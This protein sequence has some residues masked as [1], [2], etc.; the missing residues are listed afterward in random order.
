MYREGV[1]PVEDA[2]REARVLV[3]WEIENPTDMPH[4]SSGR[5]VLST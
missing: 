5:E 3:K 1:Q 2:E 4:L